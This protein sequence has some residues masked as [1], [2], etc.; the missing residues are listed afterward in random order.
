[1][2]EKEIAKIDS[3]MSRFEKLPKNADLK[4][5]VMW[6]EPTEDDKQEALRI[7]NEIDDIFIELNAFI[8]VNFGDSHKYLKKS[9][10]IKF[11]AHPIITNQVNFIQSSWANGIQSTEYLLRE[12]RAE[13][14]ARVEKGEKENKSGKALEKGLSSIANIS[15]STVIVGDV[16][17]S[18][19]SNLNKINNNLSQNPITPPSSEQKKKFKLELSH[20]IALASFTVALIVMIFGNNLLE[21]HFKN[22]ID[23]PKSTLK[24][25]VAENSDSTFHDFEMPFLQNVPILDKGLFIKYYYNSLVL[26]GANINSIKLNARGKNG[27]ALSISK[28]NTGF[29]IDITLEPFVELEYKNIFYSIEITGAHH[30]FHCIIK[31]NIKPTLD[32]R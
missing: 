26:G 18:K 22:D 12:I 8:K 9:K 19:L 23:S 2:S 17:D 4:V 14:I 16:N 25:N 5:K 24:S 3:L 29:D 1:M 15:N 32:L 11:D 7:I 27:E 31:K 30:S 6:G 21:K 13:V 10:A 28:D 20:K